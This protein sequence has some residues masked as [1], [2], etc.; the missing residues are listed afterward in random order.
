MHISMFVLVC[1]AFWK[2]ARTCVNGSQ[3]NV[4][5]DFFSMDLYLRANIKQKH[6]LIF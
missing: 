2:G 5:F 1:K 6:I 4:V 3:V